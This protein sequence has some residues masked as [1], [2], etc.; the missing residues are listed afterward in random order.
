MVVCWKKCSRLIQAYGGTPGYL[1][2]LLIC[3]AHSN[4]LWIK[5]VTKKQA[6]DGGYVLPPNYL[7]ERLCIINLNYKVVRLKIIPKN[8]ITVY[9]LLLYLLEKTFLPSFSCSFLHSYPT[10]SWNTF[11]PDGNLVIQ[12]IHQIPFAIHLHIITGANQ[13]SIIANF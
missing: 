12:K 2:H 1:E 3:M 7:F 5:S 6:Y 11:R 4:E 13:A 9:F 8:L 10:I